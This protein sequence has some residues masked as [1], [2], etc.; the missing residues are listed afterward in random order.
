MLGGKNGFGLPP[1]TKAF[2]GSDRDLSPTSASTLIVGSNY[3]GLKIPKDL[4][5]CKGIEMPCLFVQFSVEIH[6]WLEDLSEECRKTHL[7]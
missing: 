6:S 4:R 1:R 2:V 3:V 5:D 7:G